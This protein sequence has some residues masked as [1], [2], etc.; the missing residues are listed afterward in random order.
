MPCLWCWE[1]DLRPSINKT[2]TTLLADTPK[3]QRLLLAIKNDHHPQISNSCQTLRLSWLHVFLNF[4]IIVHYIKMETEAQGDCQLP[5]I[6]PVSSPRVIVLNLNLILLPPQSNLGIPLNTPHTNS[7]T[8]RT[9]SSFS[10][11]PLG[12]GQFVF[13]ILN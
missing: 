2:S 3:S 4:T 6:Y 9:T 13:L 8:P 11:L 5:L 1:F 10:Y 12:L 7:S